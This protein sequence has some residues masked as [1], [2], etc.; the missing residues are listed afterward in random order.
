MMVTNDEI[1]QWL[2]GAAPD[3]ERVAELAAAAPWFALPAAMRLRNGNVDEA[4]RRELS[5]RLA[6]LAADPEQMA[7]AADSGLALDLAAFY[8]VEPTVTPGTSDTIEKFLD[9]YGNS[10]DAENELLERLIFNPT[11]D[12]AQILAQEE[13]KNIPQAGEA[14]KGSPDDLIN[15]FIIKSKATGG[16][17]PPAASEPKA[18]PKPKPTSEVKKPAPATDS[19]LS[20]SLARIYIKKGKFSKAYEIISHLNL[21]FPEKSIY[22]ADQ[23]RFLEKIIAIEERKSMRNNENNN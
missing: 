8:P 20:E 3:A 17:F 6:L 15:D 10:S 21:N 7:M 22:F 5:A 13:E 18:E 14:P 9:T 4:E 1:R 11:A 12:Y 16:Q 23:L 2:N 19:M